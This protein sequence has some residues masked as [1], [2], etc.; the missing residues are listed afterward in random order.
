VQL[1]LQAPRSSSLDT[2]PSVDPSMF[3]TL[4]LHSTNNVPRVDASRRGVILVLLVCLL[5]NFT[6]SGFYVAWFALQQWTEI[7]YQAGRGP[8]VVRTF[9]KYVLA[10]SLLHRQIPST[11]QWVNYISKLGEYTLHETYAKQICKIVFMIT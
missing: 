7:S 3:Q 9:E 2:V 8:L 11:F 1:Q 4:L 5:R 10:A 6:V